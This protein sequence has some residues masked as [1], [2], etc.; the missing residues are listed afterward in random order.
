MNKIYTGIG[1]REVP[2]NVF[3]A[4]STEAYHL[5]GKGYTLRSGGA[6]GSDSA[7]QWGH[8]CYYSDINAVITNQEI[9]I[10]WVNFKMEEYLST[11]SNIIPQ[12]L[13]TACMEIAASV[14]PHWDKCSAGA[15]KLHARNVCQI[16]GDGL[17]IPSDFVLFYAKEVNGIV[18]GGTATA[19]NIA[20]KFNVPTINMFY[21][22]WSD[23]LEEFGL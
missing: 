14:H 1:S 20:R 9:Y 17:F 23:K 19:V 16:L 11:S 21:P 18:Q 3:E 12:H 15:K 10:P 5:A 13:N 8:E 7:F 2:E 6:K 22:D 4:M